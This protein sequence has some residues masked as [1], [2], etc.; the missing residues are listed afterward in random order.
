MGRGGHQPA[1]KGGVEVRRWCLAVMAV[2]FLFV[3]GC[4]DRTELEEEG[5]V[6]SFA[7]DT[8]P[9]PGMYVY[10]F[11]IAVP[12]EMSGPSGSPGGGGG[13][14]GGGETEKGSK[15]VSVVARSLGEAINLVNSTVERRLDFVQC[16]YVLFGEGVAREGVSP[17]VLDLLRF[18]QFR[19]T[20]FVAVV[21]GKA[22]DSFKEN[23][24]LLESSVTRYIE[25]LQRLKTFTGMVPVVQLHRFARAMDTDSEDAFTSVLAINQAVKAQDRSKASQKPGASQGGGK[26]SESPGEKARSEQQLQNPSVNFE[27]GRMQRVGGNPEEFPGA[28]VF[29]GDRLVEI[30]D[31]EEGRMLLAL[32]GELAHAFLTFRVPQGRFTVEVQQHEGGPAMSYNLA[33][34]RPVWRIAPEFDVDLVSAVGNFDTQS[35]QGLSQLRQWAE[36]EFNRQAERLVAKLQRDGSDAL[37]LGLYARRDFLTDAEWQNY[38]W[39]ERYPQ[40]SIQVQSRFVIRRVGNLLTSKRI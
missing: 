7:I 35:H 15:S 13:G 31:G 21:R 1:P 27:A 22:A 5:F 26:E 29:R 25:G 20:M 37:G 2:A 30:L 3:S 10:T 19:R 12:R 28:A 24:P 16:Q 17:H 18:R 9:A 40:F 32:R 4:W 11:R 23:K 36:Q 39:R 38:R 34:S 8:G 14:E 6:P 33:G